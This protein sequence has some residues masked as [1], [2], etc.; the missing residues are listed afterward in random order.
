LP[1]PCAGVPPPRHAQCAALADLAAATVLTRWTR[2]DGWLTAAPH[3]AWFGVAC[4]TAGDVTSLQLDMNSLGGQ[5]PESLGDLTALR[6]LCVA[7]RARRLGQQRACMRRVHA[8][9]FR[10]WRACDADGAPR[11]AAC[12]QLDA[13]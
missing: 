5:L 12:A 8:T 9:C 13:L 10:M 6:T 1:S 7:A 2:A 11:G 3:C 4:D